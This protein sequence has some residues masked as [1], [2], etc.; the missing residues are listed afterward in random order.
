MSLENFRSF[1]EKVVFEDLA[2]VNLFV[3]P[4]KSGKSNILLA[5][6]FLNSLSRNDSTNI[7]QDNVFDNDLEEEIRI[8]IEFTLTLEERTLLVNM[9]SR[10]SA[11]FKYLKLDTNS[12]FKELGYS[13]HISKY[14]ITEER[15]SAFDFAGN[16]KDL[17]VHKSEGGSHNQ[18]V[19]DLEKSLKKINKPQD[20]DTIPLEKRPGQWSQNMSILNAGSRTFE[21]RIS[22][23]VISFFRN[24]KLFPPNRNP[25]DDVQN[26]P[27]EKDLTG[28][29]DNLLRIL[30]YLW[31][32]DTK[33]YVRLI[34]LMDE[35]LGF[36]NFKM[37]DPGGRLKGLINEKGLKRDTNFSNLSFGSRQLL[38]LLVAIEESKPSHTVCIEEPELH[39]HS[40][41]QKK[42]FR[43]ILEKAKTVQFL[44]TTHSPLFTS[45]EPGT[46]T[47]LLTRKEG[48]SKGTIINNVSQLRLIRQHLGVENSDVFLSP[49]VIFVEGK[50][51]EIAIPIVGSAL[52][53]N[54]LGDKVRIINF[55]GKSKF[56]RLTEFL[57]YIDFFQTVA[58]VVADGHYDIINRIDELKRGRLN[59]K[60]LIREKGT[61]FEDQFDSKTIIE[62][63][64][65]IAEDHKFEFNMTI[66]DLDIARNTVNVVKALDDYLDK[67]GQELNKTLLANELAANIAKQ[68][69]SKV[70]R[71]ETNFE[72][73]IMKINNIVTS[74]S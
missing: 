18:Y 73:E 8:E 67:K 74:G 9:L 61:E 51:E 22:E 27:D 56:E 42:L 70:Q 1:K 2:M 52:G 17:V 26:V 34:E 25:Q 57:N 55:G 12:L 43:R 3:G 6:K 41:S 21:Y 31:R 32:N 59:F 54:Q 64:S 20:F 45:I 62:S 37:D 50:S 46:T 30:Y 35:I 13:V 53:F 71:Q 68:I 10:I 28:S 7:F 5:L 14:N 36:S 65:K 58:I 38:L 33:E 49:Y 15:L 11:E 29:G 40:A 72:K 69:E 4:N 23:W 16:K 24:I 60:S 63:M 66:E 44:L 47:H 48:R 19:L 39:L